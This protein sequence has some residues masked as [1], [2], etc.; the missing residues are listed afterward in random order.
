MTDRVDTLIAQLKALSPMPDD[1]SVSEELLE[2]YGK[3]VDELSQYRDQ[4]TIGPL[5]ASFGYGTGFGLY[6]SVV[7]LLESFASDLITPYLLSAL[8]HGE[9]GSRMWAA[10]MLG[11]S[12]NEAAIPYLV[13]LLDDSEEL[14][15][16]N[17]VLALGMIGDPSVQQHAERL[18][19][20][21][22]R[23]VRH[24]VEVTLAQLKQ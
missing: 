16:A 22:S 12:H 14:V 18:R 21:P 5:I 4:R 15:R 19:G 6:W 10:S 9:R 23:D 3:I 8:Q 17:A 2:T 7:D 1:T 13:A 20:D 24:A 11:W